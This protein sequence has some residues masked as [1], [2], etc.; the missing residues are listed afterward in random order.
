MNVGRS[1][2]ERMIDK[3]TGYAAGDVPSLPPPRRLAPKELAEGS[4][5]LLALAAA[6]EA[7]Y[8][9]GEADNVSGPKTRALRAIVARMRTFDAKVA[10]K[11]ESA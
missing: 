3:A 11:K 9:S 4:D 6:A 7:W 5:V 8:D 1:P 2:I 10:A